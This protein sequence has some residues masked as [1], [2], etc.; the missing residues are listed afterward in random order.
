MIE[1]LMKKHQITANPPSTPRLSIADMLT[2]SV[3]LSR[4]LMSL[5]QAVLAWIIETLQPF[6][7]VEQSLFQ[8]IFQC[9]HHKL[10]RRNSDT[11]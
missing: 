2:R 1:H 7:V 9:I 8:R 5:E 6:I 4:P 3:P 10:P 11:V